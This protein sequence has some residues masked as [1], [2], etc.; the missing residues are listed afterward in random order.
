MTGVLIELRRYVA[1][2]GRGAEVL[3]RFRSYTLE[4]FAV[5]AFTVT[6]FWADADD[7]DVLLYTLEWRD[8]AE[9]DAGWSGFV[10][11]P[12]WHEI[13]RRTEANGP[14]IDRIERTFMIPV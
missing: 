4:L 5:H 2:P 14:I 3:E 10:D 6:A 13:V 1:V 7:P 9:M 11:D 8:R 12:R